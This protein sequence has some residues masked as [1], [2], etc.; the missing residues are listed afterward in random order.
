MEHKL[1]IL[2]L[3]IFYHIS[4]RNQ[5]I[6]CRAKLLISIRYIDFGQII[7]F[8]RIFQSIFEYLHD[9]LIRLILGLET[10][11]NTDKGLLHV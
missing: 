5:Y 11:I 6:F 3:F 2:Y 7:D 1:N 10:Q 4:N 9:I 8:D